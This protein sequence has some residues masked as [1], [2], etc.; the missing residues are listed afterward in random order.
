M[1]EPPIIAFVACQTMA[2]EQELARLHVELVQ[3]HE[4]DPAGKE[5]DLH[6]LRRQRRPEY[7]AKFIPYSSVPWFA[8]TG[9]IF[10]NRVST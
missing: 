10:A 7:Q 9:G 6:C 8:A 3:L 2:S 1:N 5:K 4:W